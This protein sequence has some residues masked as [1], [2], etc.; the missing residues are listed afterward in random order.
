M[1]DELSRCVSV[2]S[3]VAW[4]PPAAVGAAAAASAEMALGLLTYTGYGFVGAFTL[5]LCVEL[6]ALGFGFWSSP[7]DAAPPWSG[8]RRAWLLLLLAHAAAAI[9]ASSWEAVGGL[10]GT[11]LSRGL[12]L[13]FLGA[14]PLYATGVVLG[15]PALSVGGGP[16]SS[17][18]VAAA[19]GAAAGFGLL[20]AAGVALQLAAF[21]FV[22]GGLAVSVGALV[23]SRLLDARERVWREWAAGVG[24]A[25]EPQP[26]PGLF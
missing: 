7:T 15:A 1:P 4:I 18:R 19:L 12:G 23:H 2:T 9:V 5:V 10:A 13:A 20:G 25:P 17:P 8:M 6:L 16:A 3:R 21:P 26:P 22:M 14:L 24:G 11:F